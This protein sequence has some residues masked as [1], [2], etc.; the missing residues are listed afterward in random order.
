MIEISNL[1]KIYKSSNIK[2]VDNLSLTVNAGEI[3]GF[4]GPN[5]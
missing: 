3:Y 1:T 5:G 2:A 4:L